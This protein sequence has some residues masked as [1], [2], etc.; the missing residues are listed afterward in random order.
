TT[1]ATRRQV[2]SRPRSASVVL[3]CRNVV[4]LVAVSYQQHTLLNLPRSIARMRPSIAC[5]RE[6]DSD[7]T[8]YPSGGMHGFFRPPSPRPSL[9]ARL[10]IRRNQTRHDREA[11][12]PEVLSCWNGHS[13]LG[14]PKPP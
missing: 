11:T 3:A 7:S 6:V 12:M 9:A 14:D 4:D 10:L 13:W 1:P 8:V 5:L 2:K